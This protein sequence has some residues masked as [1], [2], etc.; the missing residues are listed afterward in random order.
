MAQKPARLPSMR[1]DPVS[2]PSIEKS[3][4][5]AQSTPALAPPAAQRDLV[6]KNAYVD[7]Y[8]R[9]VVADDKNV[10]DKN[11][12]APVL[13]STPQNN[14]TS[15]TKLSDS[16]T[17]TDSETNNNS[18]TNKDSEL[19]SEEIVP[20]PETGV[21]ETT[22][23]EEAATEKSSAPDNRSEELT[24]ADQQIIN[25]LQARDR[26]VRSHEAAHQ[27]AGG[28]VVGG[29]SFTYQQ[30]PDGHQYAIGGEVSVNLSTSGSNPE[31]VIAK[32]AQVRAAALAPADPSAQDRSVAA[33]ANAITEQAREQIRTEERQAAEERQTQE[34]A[35]NQAAPLTS[36]DTKEEAPNPPPPLLGPDTQQAQAIAAYELANQRPYQ[37][38]VNLVA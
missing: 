22:A 32:M 20:E 14:E 18:E 12:A 30:G 36:A 27:A 15:Q 10:S 7:S 6:A 19:N 5:K 9:S 26:E 34:A 13:P 21:E 23:S 38:G 1:I 24:A 31:A 35:K 29:A 4:S 2:T 33:T 25:E 37:S 28:D 17:I 16:E 8:E 11:D 3:A